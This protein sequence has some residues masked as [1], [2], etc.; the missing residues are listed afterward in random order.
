MSHTDIP[1]LKFPTRSLSKLL[2][3]QTCREV[4]K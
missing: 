1:T 4:S 3:W 2:N